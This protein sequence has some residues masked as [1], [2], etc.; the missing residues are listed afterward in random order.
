M[1]SI[2]LEGRNS[3]IEE[4]KIAA[5]HIWILSERMHNNTAEYVCFGISIEKHTCYKGKKQICKL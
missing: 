4:W 5:V 3:S 1:N 2:Y